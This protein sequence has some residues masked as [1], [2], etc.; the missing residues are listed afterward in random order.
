MQK[1]DGS[2]GVS[3]AFNLSK[4]GGGPVIDIGTVI[5]LIR[6][7]GQAKTNQ[8]KRSNLQQNREL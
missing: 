3:R 7:F 5:D 6:K 2:E 4:S 8:R 1:P